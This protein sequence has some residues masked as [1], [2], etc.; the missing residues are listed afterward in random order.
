MIIKYYIQPK[1]EEQYRDVIDYFSEFLETFGVDNWKCEVEDEPEPQEKQM[2]NNN[3]MEEIK[4]KIV[5]PIEI[6]WECPECHKI[7]HDF[8]YN[9]PGTTR[10]QCDYCGNS[11]IGSR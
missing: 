11:F 1:T 3:E 2:N 9:V 8:F 7:N 5:R 10:L 4:I 6:E